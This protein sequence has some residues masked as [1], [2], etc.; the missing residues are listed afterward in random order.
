MI[1]FMICS[2][3][4]VRNHIL[5]RQV[6]IPFRTGQI[7]FLDDRI[8]RGH[9]GDHYP[10]TVGLATALED[11]LVEGAGNSDTVLAILLLVGEVTIFLAVQITLHK[12]PDDM[13]DQLSGLSSVV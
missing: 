7:I 9:D 10:P 5:A 4:F 3:P 6:V 13:A 1:Q 8:L 12:I 11:H 2:P